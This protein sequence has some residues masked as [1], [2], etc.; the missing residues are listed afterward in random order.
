MARYKTRRIILTS[1]T[2]IFVG[3]AVLMAAAGRHS[4]S[5][6]R[7]AMASAAGPSTSASGPDNTIWG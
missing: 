5:G 3:L 2:L 4:S 1:M 7:P 6:T